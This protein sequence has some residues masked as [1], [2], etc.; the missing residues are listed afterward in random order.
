MSADG[1]FGW[2]IFNPEWICV[3]TEVMPSGN[4][5]LAITEMARALLAYK[6]E[7]YAGRIEPEHVRFTFAGSGPD[8]LGRV[9]LYLPN[10]VGEFQGHH[11]A[12][13]WV[14]HHDL[15]EAVIAQRGSAVEKELRAYGT[16]LL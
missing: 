6:D 9:E 4:Y 5:E 12:L 15:Y 13:E 7:H 3:H 1:E 2:L 10:P 8:L 16:R 14:S 11:D